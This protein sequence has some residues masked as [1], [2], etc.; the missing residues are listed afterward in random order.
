[1]VQLTCK[2]EEAYF[3]CFMSENTKS[4]WCELDSNDPVLPL[5]CFNYGA[6]IHVHLDKK[7]HIVGKTIFNDG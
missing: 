5:K 2:A 1:M 4:I 6:V 3:E 7:S